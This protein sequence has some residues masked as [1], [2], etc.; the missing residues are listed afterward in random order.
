[1]TLI[2]DISKE[3]TYYAVRSRGKGGQHVN[4]NATKVELYFSVDESKILTDEQKAILKN[5]IGHMINA[6]GF[7]R[8]TSEEARTQL[9]NKDIVNEKMTALLKKALTPKKRRVPT[10]KPRSADEKRLTEK[11]ITAEKKSKRGEISIED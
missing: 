5:E 2:P 10:R 9:E 1:M 11:H 8:I 4:K 3:C 6:D 7:I